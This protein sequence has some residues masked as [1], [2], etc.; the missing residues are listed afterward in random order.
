MPRRPIFFALTLASLTLAGCDRTTT[1]PALVDA[2]SSSALSPALNTL[3]LSALTPEELRVILNV[4]GPEIV[5]RVL[6]ESNDLMIDARARIRAA[7]QHGADTESAEAQLQHIN[8]LLTQATAL[9][10]TDPAQALSVVSEAAQQLDDLNAAAA[11]LRRLRGVDDLFP[12]ISGRLP[13]AELRRHAQLNGEAQAALRAGGRAAANEKLEAVRAEEIRL[14]LLATEN[15]A[16]TEL[17]A[18]V[19]TSITELRST[20]KAQ[21]AAGQDMGRALRMLNIATDLHNRGT[22]AELTGDY[23]TALDLASHA[24]GLLNSLRHLLD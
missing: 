10:A 6:T 22:R 4:V 2:A 16:A 18:Q 14:V 9:K 12:E 17:V 23:A 5:Q 8:T 11:G 1:D 19:G 13:A 20:I 15:R 24:S 21:R 7:A 3:K